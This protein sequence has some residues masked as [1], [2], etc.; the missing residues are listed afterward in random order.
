[1]EIISDMNVELKPS[2]FNI[3]NI[4]NVSHNNDYHILDLLLSQ[5]DDVLDVE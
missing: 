5:I 4:D 1:M 2:H 3:Q